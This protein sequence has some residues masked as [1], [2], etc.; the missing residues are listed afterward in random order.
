[1]NRV[2]PVILVASLVAVASLGACKAE[3]RQR[4]TVPGQTVTIQTPEGEQE[5]PV[6][7]GPNPP[8]RN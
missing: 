5:L 2:R 3:Q 8:A 1:M 4:E 6:T 7:I